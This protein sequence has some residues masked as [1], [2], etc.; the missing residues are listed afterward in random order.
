ANVLALGARVIGSG[1]ALEV[2]RTWLGA[3]PQ[4][5]RHQRRVAKLSAIEERY[6]H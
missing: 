2:V 4:S 6:R 3:T 5:G 1:L